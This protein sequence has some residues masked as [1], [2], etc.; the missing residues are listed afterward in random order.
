M[1]TLL[2]SNAMAANI[3]YDEEIC[4]Y[5][6]EMNIS[7][8]RTPVFTKSTTVAL[9]ADPCRV[10]QSLRMMRLD[11]ATL[12]DGLSEATAIETMLFQETETNASHGPDISNNACIDKDVCLANVIS[13]SHVCEATVLDMQ[14]PPYT[15]EKYKSPSWMGCVVPAT[16]SVSD[17]MRPYTGKVLPSVN[18]E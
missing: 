6:Q 3:H 10:Y 11:E 9:K 16:Y 18:I 1:D 5:L 15:E 8:Y 7:K 12:L 17:L 14:T 13:V 4:A 2:I